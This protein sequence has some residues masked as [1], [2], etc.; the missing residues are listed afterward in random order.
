MENYCL[1]PYLLSN[2][3][4]VSFKAILFCLGPILKISV[5]NHGDTI[6]WLDYS[7][8]IVGQKI[9]NIVGRPDGHHRYKTEST[10]KGFE[11]FLIKNIIQN[12]NLDL[13]ENILQGTW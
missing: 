7:A 9:K 2:P 12:N 13:I 3:I 11:W 10:E 6:F 4:W 1:K 5:V 8:F